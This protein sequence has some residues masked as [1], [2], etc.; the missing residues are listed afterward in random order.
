[1][2]PT[3]SPSGEARACSAT[4]GACAETVG[5]HTEFALDAVRREGAPFSP[6]AQSHDAAGHPANAG[7]RR[8]DAREPTQP[9]RA[10]EERRGTTLDHGHAVRIAWA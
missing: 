5:A 6:F 1:M 2:P 3:K 9:R 7:S 8:R 4:D 10:R